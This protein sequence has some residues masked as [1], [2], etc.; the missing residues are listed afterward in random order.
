MFFHT[1]DSQEERRNFGG[2]CFVEIQNCKLPAGSNIDTVVD[3]DIEHWELTSLYCA[4]ENRFCEI[5]ADIFGDGIYNNKESGPVDIYGLNYFPQDRVEAILAR[6]T[7]EKPEGYAELL[8]WL[9][10][11]KPENGIYVLGV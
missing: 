10:N 3:T 1:F 2:S 11:H 5:Y 7:E 4:D 6:L 8:F 9:C